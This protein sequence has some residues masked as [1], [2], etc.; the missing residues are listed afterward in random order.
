MCFDN[1][2]NL[3]NQAHLFLFLFQISTTFQRVTGGGSAHAI[4]FCVAICADNR[5]ITKNF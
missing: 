4:R 1:E 5:K 2:D 3:E